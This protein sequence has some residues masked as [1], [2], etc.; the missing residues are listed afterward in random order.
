M[1]TRQAQHDTTHPPT[2]PALDALLDEALSQ[3]TSPA[4]PVPA[5][6]PD[7]A[8]RI[9]AKTLPMLGARPVLARIGPTL[10]RV[11]AVVAVVVGAGI[12]AMMLNTQTTQTDGSDDVALIG[13]QLREIDRAIEPGNTL[14][15]EQLDVLALRVD[16]LSSDDAW[17]PADQDTNARLGEAV[18]RFEFDRFSDDAMLLLDDGSTLF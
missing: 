17:G 10:L 7:L 1:D 9:I 16:L 14:I 12:V 18:A 11:A 2:D 4:G 3:G 8:E 6:D 5:A 15:D 13:S